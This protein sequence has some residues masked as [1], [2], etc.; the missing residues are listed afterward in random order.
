M[1]ELG[2]REPHL[3]SGLGVQILVVALLVF[4]YTQAARQLKHQK[5][6]VL[7]MR[8]QLTQAQVR[9]AKEG[10]SDPGQFKGQLLQ[11]RS[12]LITPDQL[13]DWAKR[14]E[15]LARDRFGFED[16]QVTVGDPER[17]IPMPCADRPIFEVQ[18]YALELEGKTTSRSCAGFL[19]SLRQPNVKLLC[20]LETMELQAQA[21]ETG[22]PLKVRLHWLVAA[23]AKKPGTLPAAVDPSSE[24]GSWPPL[25]PRLS[26]GLREEPFLSPLTNPNAARLPAQAQTPFRLE[27]ILWDSVTPTCVINGNV[28][29]ISDWL[30]G[31]QVVLI[32]PKAVLLQGSAGE[33]FLKL[34]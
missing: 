26:W 4:A 14:I 28:L 10:K 20:P 11:L 17:T 25:T 23:V 33:L 16:L 12:S 19:A 30:K 5:E 15:L 2:R 34:S 31:Y 24:T 29:K 18:L 3:L 22:F 27:G 21:L 8:E 13:A 7:Q 32:T 6:M 9:V 1:L